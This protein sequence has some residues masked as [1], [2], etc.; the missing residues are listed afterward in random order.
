MICP[1]G[2]ASAMLAA[3][4]AVPQMAAA[5]Q[6]TCAESCL[7]VPLH[8]SPKVKLL[9][10]TVQLDLPMHELETIDIEVEA[11][12]LPLV[13]APQEPDGVP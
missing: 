11:S 3:S 13:K 9:A 2:Q 4:L 7:A 10:L 5:L 1:E 6:V 8:G 12:Q